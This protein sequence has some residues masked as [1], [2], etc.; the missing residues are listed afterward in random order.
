ML[1]G[2][3]PIVV[4]VRD[5]SLFLEA[6]ERGSKACLLCRYFVAFMFDTTLGVA[7]SI[8]LHT[9]LLKAAKAKASSNTFAAS[10]FNCGN[11]G[12]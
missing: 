6:L 1:G 2:F 5:P 4:P 12:K 11:Y 7:L 9:L 3:P 10:I 8:G